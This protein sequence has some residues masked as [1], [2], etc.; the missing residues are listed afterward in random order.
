MSWL[1]GPCDP[2]APEP[3]VIF[4]DPAPEQEWQEAFE[5]AMTEHEKPRPAD[6]DELDILRSLADDPESGLRE[7]APDVWMVDREGG[8]S[9][10]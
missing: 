5:A 6:G 7:I 9:A 8:D 4:S 2:D 1:S 3:I 10:R